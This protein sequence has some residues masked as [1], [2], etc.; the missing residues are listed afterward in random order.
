MVCRISRGD[1]NELHWSSAAM[2]L[3][4]R[5]DSMRE[6]FDE[7][8]LRAPSFGEFKSIGRNPVIRIVPRMTIRD[9]QYE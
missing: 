1:R 3:G 5:C 2:V 8:E 7:S 4:C 6:P 9:F